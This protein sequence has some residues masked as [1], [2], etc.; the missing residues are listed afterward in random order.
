MIFLQRRCR[1]LGSKRCCPR[2]TL[3]MLE[4]MHSRNHRSACALRSPT[5]L[6]I[7][8]DLSTQQQ[9]FVFARRSRRRSWSEHPSCSTHDCGRR[10]LSIR[11]TQTFK[12]ASK[13]RSASVEMGGSHG[14]RVRRAGGTRKTPARL[15][16]EFHGELDGAG[17]VAF[18]SGERQSW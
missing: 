5:A 10:A 11:V 2:R 17:N 8:G 3:D 9:A 16:T 12:P 7:L 6:T 14:E 13:W 18:S 4:R 15:P 1:A